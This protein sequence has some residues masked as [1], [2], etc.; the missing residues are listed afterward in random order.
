MSGERRCL[1]ALYNRFTSVL[2]ALVSTGDPNASSVA[3][4][5]AALLRPLHNRQAHMQ[6]TRSF[7][8]P[9]VQLHY[10]WGHAAPRPVNVERTLIQPLL[11]EVEDSDGQRLRPR[12]QTFPSPL[13]RMV[14]QFLPGR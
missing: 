3:Y 4:L 14:I 11:I 2:A 7:S 12:F 13:P 5:K 10:V 8:Q 1:Q 6:L 9:F